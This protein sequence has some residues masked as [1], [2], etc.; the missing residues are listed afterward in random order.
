MFVALCGDFWQV[1]MIVMLW[2]VRRSAIMPLTAMSIINQS[3]A[4]DMFILANLFFV[5]TANHRDV[6][7][8]HHLTY[9]LDAL[10]LSASHLPR[11]HCD[12]RCA[13]SAAWCCCGA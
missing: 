6:N 8:I 3:M 4:K 13:L 2:I 12:N 10:G 9:S 11:S 1:L 7:P 5:K